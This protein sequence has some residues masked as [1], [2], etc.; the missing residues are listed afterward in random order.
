MPFI[1][2]TKGSKCKKS[3]RKKKQSACN[4]YYYCIALSPSINALISDG[5]MAIIK[6]YISEVTRHSRATL[7]CGIEWNGMAW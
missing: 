4:C 7:V 6:V 5:M 2:Q 3:G 1:K